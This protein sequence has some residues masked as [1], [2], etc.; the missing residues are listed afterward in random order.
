MSTLGVFSP[1]ERASGHQTGDLEIR[2]RER[3]HIMSKRSLVARV[4]LGLATSTILSACG[5]GQDV[6]LGSEDD[7]V[8]KRPHADAG[9]RSRDDAGVAAADAG[10][11]TVVPT[12]SLTT[13]PPYSCSGAVHEVGVAGDDVAV[14]MLGVS[15]V[16]AAEGSAPDF[17]RE[18][19][20]FEVC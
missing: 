10:R 13:I 5:A 1:L 11:D 2:A 20:V 16:P 17:T 12:L 19:I 4:A 18:S 6:S 3:R 8:R 15:V 7:P 9:S 14:G